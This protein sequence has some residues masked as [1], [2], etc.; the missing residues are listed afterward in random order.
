MIRPPHAGATIA[1][2]DD[3]SLRG[4]PGARVVRE[5]EFLGVVA[6]S[7]WDAI[8]AAQA[9]KVNWNAAKAPFPSMQD[10]HSHI[11]KAPVVKRHAEVDR[12]NIEAAF[13]GASKVIEAEYE[14]PFQS[15]SSMGPACAVA[16]IRASGVSTVWTGS[17]KPHH[18]Q[19]G[20]AKLC[21]IP[22]DRLRAI[23]V[24]GPGS[25]GRNDAGDCAHEAA[26]LSKLTGRPVRLQYMRYEG[27]GWDPKSPACVFR[28]RAAIDAGG[29]V[30]GY[31]FHAKGFSRQDMV[32]TEADP[33]HCLAGMNTGYALKPTQIFG[34]PSESYGFAS[35]HLW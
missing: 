7:E 6:E 24:P 10:L 30:I 15:H 27:T 5:K 31:D 17:Q 20:T 32:Q 34:V 19:M 12:G 18:V 1:S 8:Q 22:I 9:L 2:V 26:L 23:W 29:N 25:Y 35:K 4:I 28:G 21:D 11:R 13:K 3:A 14:W 16:D 33:A